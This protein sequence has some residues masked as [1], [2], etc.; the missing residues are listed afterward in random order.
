[1]PKRT[2]PFQ[3]MVHFLRTHW[4]GEGV[5]VTE[6]KMLYDSHLEIDREVDVVIEGKFAEE[7]VVISLEVIEHNRRASITWVEQMISKHRYLPTTKLILVSKSGFTKNA[8][9]A[10]AR[11]G[12][13]VQTQTPEFYRGGQAAS[14]SLGLSISTMRF[15]LA[16]GTLHLLTMS[17]EVTGHPVQ[18]DGLVYLD[19]GPRGTTAELALDVLHVSW[20]HEQFLKEASSN[21]PDEEWAD[22]SFQFPLAGLGYTIRDRETGESF[23]LVEI[24]VTG[25]CSFDQQELS[26]GMAALGGRRFGT[27]P[28]ELLGLPGLFM[29]VEGPEEHVSLLWRGSADRPIAEQEQPM[30]PSGRF[31]EINAVSRPD[32]WDT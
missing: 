2:T 24:G 26:F 7:D 16:D 17:G 4:A 11:E 20:V 23:Q 8:V 5:S 19:D 9:S 3:M 22:F 12:G 25:S 13:W 28:A 30:G 21:P 6:S 29:Q 1:M 18:H 31:P 15:Q 27:A 32:S 10:V 14:S